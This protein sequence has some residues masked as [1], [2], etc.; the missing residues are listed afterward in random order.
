MTVDGS[1]SSSNNLPVSAKTNNSNE[2]L[3]AVRDRLGGQ[4]GAF[5]CVNNQHV[6]R[7]SLAVSATATH[8][9]E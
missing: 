1:E 7:L 5:Y 8:S 6:R 3:R 9:N 4:L 2:T